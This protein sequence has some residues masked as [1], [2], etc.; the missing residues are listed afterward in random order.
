[1]DGGTAVLDYRINIKEASSSEY[2]VAATGVTALSYT[3]LNLVLGTTY[4]LTVEARN[5]IGYSEPSDPLQIL[6]ALVP[7]Q[8]AAPTTLNSGVEVVISWSE[9]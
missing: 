1:L 9:T 3:L 7:E 4:D 5:S 6:H 2:S 8:P